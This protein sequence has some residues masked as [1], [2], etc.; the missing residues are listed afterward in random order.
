MYTVGDIMTPELVTLREEDDLAVAEWALALRRFRHLPVTR[1]DQLVGVVTQRDLLRAR[2][3]FEQGTTTVAVSEFMTRDP[4]TVDPTMPL[5]EAA[6]IM[7]LRKI[8]CLPV[9]AD[10]RLVGLITEGD[11]VRFARN[12][13]ADLDEGTEALK[14][15]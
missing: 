9:V 15:L 8:G 4:V 13:A 7:V 1:G 14:K 2:S 10:N 12:L 11:L 6:D 3:R 5:Q